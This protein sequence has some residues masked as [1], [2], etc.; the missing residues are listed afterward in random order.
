MKVVRVEKRSTVSCGIKRA[1]V[2]D[3]RARAQRR[4]SALVE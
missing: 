3:R 2:G 1:V 4:E